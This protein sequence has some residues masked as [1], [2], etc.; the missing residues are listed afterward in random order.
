M[1]SQNQCIAILIVLITSTG[2]RAQ[3]EG[4]T[5]VFSTQLSAENPKKVKTTNSGPAVSQKSSGSIDVIWSEDFS[6]GL[7]GQGDNGAW[8][9]SGPEG[10]LWFQTFPIGAANGYDPEA[11]LDNPAYGPYV[12]NYFGS[13]N[14]INSATASNGFIMLDADRFNSTAT[15][16][17]DPDES[18]T[19]E[20]E[21]TRLR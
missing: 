20:N 8:T 18:N 5:P 16:P 1:M 21:F 13:G 10:D 17:N 11:P 12:P 4:L 14:T 2:V 3:T 7:A 19:V 6:D 9:T 15:S